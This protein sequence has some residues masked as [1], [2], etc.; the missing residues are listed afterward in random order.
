M[1][2]FAVVFAKTN[3]ICSNSAFR[4]AASRCILLSCSF[5]VL[6]R[7]ALTKSKRRDLQYA[8]PPPP[9]RSTCDF[10]GSTARYARTS[11]SESRLIHAFGALGM[12]DRDPLPCAPYL[13]SSSGTLCV[14][15]ASG[16]AAKWCVSLLRVQSCSEFRR[17]L[18]KSSLATILA[19]RL[20][21]CSCRPQAEHRCSL[22][23]CQH[24]ELRAANEGF[25]CGHWAG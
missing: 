18:S 8:R 15:L 24:S 16:T 25:R 10:L 13:C 20:V 19:Q 4:T 2:K 21:C 3:A 17:L 23:L 9:S 5:A 7:K 6:A 14:R 12:T 1:G 11:L 22:L